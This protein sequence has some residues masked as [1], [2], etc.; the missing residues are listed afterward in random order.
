MRRRLTFAVFLLALSVLACNAPQ[1][2]GVDVLPT[3]VPAATELARTE[4][5]PTASPSTELPVAEGPTATPTSEGPTSTPVP[6]ETSPTM[7]PSPT[8]IIMCTPPACNEGEGSSTAG[9]ECI[10]K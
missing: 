2:G 10:W 7:T 5:P 6:E 8:P 1:P 9:G 4:A 3:D